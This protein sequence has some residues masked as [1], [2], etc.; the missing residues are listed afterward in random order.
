MVAAESAKAARAY[1]DN[2]ISPCR[3]RCHEKINCFYFLANV[4][5]SLY[6]CKLKIGFSICTVFVRSIVA[7]ERFHGGGSR[8]ADILA[9]QHFLYRSPHDFAISGEGNMIDIPHVQ[10]E[11]LLP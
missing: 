8:G 6:F 4:G 1:A 3:D 9:P 2:H 5:F 11:F 7:V 10:L